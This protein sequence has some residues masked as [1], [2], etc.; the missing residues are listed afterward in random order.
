MLDAIAQEIKS[1]RLEAGLSQE[2][3]YFQTGIHIGRIESGR[4]NMTVTT[5]VRI[6]AYFNLPPSK[7]LQLAENKTA[8][9]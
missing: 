2:T 1:L 9:Q 5:L 8:E 7:L 6:S 4:A 3:V